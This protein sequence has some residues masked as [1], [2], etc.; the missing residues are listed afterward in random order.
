MHGALTYISNYVCTGGTNVY[1]IRPH[2]ELC[3]QS[4]GVQGNTYTIQTY[5]SAIEACEKMTMPFNTKHYLSKT[6][7]YFLTTL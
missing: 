7:T 3:S 6:D 1:S 2:M 4:A 5:T